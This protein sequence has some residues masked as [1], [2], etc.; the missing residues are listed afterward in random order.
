MTVEIPFE[1]W[2][3]FCEE[4]TAHVEAM[5][6]IRVQSNGD[7]RLVAQD[8]RL[9]SASFDEN[10]DAC[11]SVLVLEFGT[12]GH[13]AS[14]LRV[15]GP[16]RLILRKERGDDHFHLLE[17]PAESELTVITFRPGISPAILKDLDLPV[18]T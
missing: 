15:V 18:R 4:L 2:K 12:V 8:V 13:K 7:L 9:Q 5:V 3:S 14:Q 16:A 10:S 11:N 6:D 1:S 17:M